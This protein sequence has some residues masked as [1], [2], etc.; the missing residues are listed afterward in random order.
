[1][2]KLD[3]FCSIEE[4]LKNVHGRCL[5]SGEDYTLAIPDNKDCPSV[6]LNDEQIWK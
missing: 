4:C 5:A 3:G 1:M 2:S 6:E